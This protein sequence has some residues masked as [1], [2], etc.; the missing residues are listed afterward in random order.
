MAVLLHMQWGKV[1]ILNLYD[2]T[3]HQHS[4]KQV[5][6]KLWSR[7]CMGGGATASE[8]TIWLSDF[9]LHHPLWDK[10]RNSHLFTRLNLE[11]SQVLIDAVADFDMQM[12]LPKDILTLWALATRNYTWPDT[13]SCPLAHQHPHMLLHALWRTA[14]K[15]RPH[16]HSHRVGHRD[17]HSDI[18]VAPQL[19][20]S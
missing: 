11:K 14:S 9:N 5:I 4:L 3:E 19:Q 10:E 18:Y 13:F 15:N 1:L 6:Q 16:P 2:D 17:Q 7:V 8:H 20:E 12:T